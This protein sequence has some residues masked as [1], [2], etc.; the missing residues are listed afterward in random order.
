GDLFS[1]VDVWFRS[2]LQQYEQARDYL[3][4]QQAVV[5]PLVSH[6]EIVG[7]LVVMAEQIRPA[8]V[9]AVE[10]FANQA[11]A[12]LD[13][14]R[15]LAA[16]RRERRR[17]ETL[18]E[19][20][21]ILSSTL[22]LQD[23]LHQVMVQL[24][25]L[26]DYDSSS[27]FLLEDEQFH[28]VAA[29]GFPDRDQVLGVR[30]DP[31]ENAIFAELI[32]TRQT[33]LISNTYDDPRWQRPEVAEHVVSWLAAPLVAEGQLLGVLMA[34]KSQSDFYTQEDLR[35]VAA[36]ADQ[37]SVAMQRA[38]HYDESQQRLRELSSLAQV[39]KALNE[40]PDLD[41]MLEIVLVNACDLVGSGR[42]AVALV[43]RPGGWLR[44]VAARGHEG[45]AVDRINQAQLHLPAN[46]DPEPAIRE[47]I[48]I[49]PG[50]NG[51]ES[52]TSVVLAVGGQVIGLIELET[53]KGDGSAHRPLA[54]LAD[55]A[56]AAIEKARLY[57]DTRKA[58]EELRELDRLKDEFV[59]NVSHELRTPLT[60]IKGYVEYLLEGYAGELTQ[61]QR[62]SLEIVLNRGDAIILLVNDIISLKQAEMQQLELEPTSL[63][64]IATACVQGAQVAA[65]QAK[66]QIQ[67][68]LQRPLPLVMGESTRLGQVFDNLLGNA[69]KFSP[70]GGLVTVRLL[71]SG[72]RVVAEISDTGIGIAPDRLDKIWERF[73]QVDSTTTRRSSGTGLG[74]ASV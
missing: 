9:P 8:D 28:C 24:R 71:Q 23:A 66:V 37:V 14:A 15:L 11:S 54:A 40:A 64:M 3:S 68:E 65:E 26:V 61:E 53:A 43:E 47:R 2:R 7:V 44:V 31:H 73:Y 52:Y 72:E 63:E 22:D 48:L 16:E 60:F 42:G 21:R 34:D 51:H 50:R 67:M 49:E 57:R 30:Y 19:V 10:A 69:L 55:L 74:L 4:G 17:A 59:Q 46:L 62:E 70:D 18:S 12:A 25:R 20:A 36:F 33:M 39:S 6:H 58:Y 38:K 1:V 27:L 13:N 35:V 56:A 32:R 41:A 5:A 45:E 29:E